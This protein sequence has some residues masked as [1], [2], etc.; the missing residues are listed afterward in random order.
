M[1][2]L[3]NEK[4]QALT[5]K[6]VVSAC[7]DINKLNKRGYNFLYLCQGFIAH[8]NVYGFIDHYTYD[9]LKKDIL[10]NQRDNQW[11]NWRPHEKDYEYYMTKK[12]VYNAIVKALLEE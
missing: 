3:M 6:N 8:Y 10:D 5:V 11:V 1:L 12:A 7:K 4:E 9:S 2:T